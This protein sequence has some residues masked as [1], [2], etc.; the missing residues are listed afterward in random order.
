MFKKNFSNPSH[1]YV[2]QIHPIFMSFFLTYSKVAH[3]QITLLKMKIY[4][5]V[6]LASVN[7]PV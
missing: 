7:S 3:I 2:F 1:F 5:L 6:R 4:L